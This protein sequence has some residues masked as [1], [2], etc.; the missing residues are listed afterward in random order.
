MNE[1][2][3]TPDPK[4]ATVLEN[5]K[6]SIA[7]IDDI[8]ELK[9][10]HDVALGFEKSWE[11]HYRSSGFGRDQMLLGWEVKIRSERRMGELLKEM[12]HLSQG[13]DRKSSN[14]MKL[15][16]LDDLCISKSQSF[17]YQLLT[18]LDDFEKE[19]SEIVNSNNSEI[20]IRLTSPRKKAE[21][22][23]KELQRKKLAKEGENKTIPDGY[24]LHNTSFISAPIEK[25]SIDLIL[26]DPPYP[27]EYLPLWRELGKFARLYLKPGKFLIAYTGLA[28]LPEVINMLS[29]NM[30]YYWSFCML[31]TS[32]QLV[33]KTN[34]ITEW[35][36]I[37][38]FQKPPFKKLEN[39]ISDLL[40]GGQREKDL[41]DW[42][43]AEWHAKEIIERFTVENEV[44][45]DP[46]M[47]AGTFPYVANKLKRKAI[48][49]EI[50][51]DT[52][53][54]VKERIYGNTKR[55]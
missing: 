43:Q 14:A 46:M 7:E 50:D 4:L 27:K 30:D 45:A 20:E 44:V 35:K 26:T 31:F 29:E 16:S 10:L 9:E 17:R 32:N 28:Y 42:Q 2:Q 39:T 19:I 51:K 25:D 36:P 40:R 15:D 6:K 41:H 13:G 11:A 38:I 12:E 1:I 34:I 48:G 54:I 23:W 53:N 5:I 37:L 3:L 47:G 33:H 52:F 18:I 8:R 21:Q 24:E 22:I 49:I 55:K